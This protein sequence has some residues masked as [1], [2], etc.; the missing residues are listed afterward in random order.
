MNLFHFLRRR[1]NPVRQVPAEVAQ[2]L[3]TLMACIHDAELRRLD[4]QRA[5]HRGYY[6]R[7]ADRVRRWL[8]ETGIDQSL[9]SPPFAGTDPQAEQASERI[10]CIAWQ[11]Q[12]LTSLVL[13]TDR[14]WAVVQSLPARRRVW[15][16]AALAG[17]T[18]TLDEHRRGSRTGNGGETGGV[19][20][21]K[22]ESCDG[23]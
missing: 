9:G 11:V 23:P 17:L 10:A 2:A 18:E 12:Q 20:V 4:E 13:G 5:E 21:G 16:T 19:V 8:A 3:R 15:V 1:P 7:E 22:G 14:I 6:Y